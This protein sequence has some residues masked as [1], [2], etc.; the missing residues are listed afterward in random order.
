MKEMTI[1]KSAASPNGIM[2]FLAEGDKLF[3]AFR[4]HNYKGWRQEAKSRVPVGYEPV[5]KP[6][7]MKDT[8]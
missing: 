2:V 4:T 8:L 5:F 6:T 1:F 3:Q 7:T